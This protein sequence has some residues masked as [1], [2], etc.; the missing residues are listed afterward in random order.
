VSEGAL[1]QDEPPA[2]VAKEAERAL[3][4]LFRVA[5]ERY[6]LRAL[7]VHKVVEPGWINRLPRLPPSV[8]GITQHRGRIL[9]VV[10]L[11]AFF[12][13]PLRTL[14]PTSATRVLV[15]DKGQRNL[16]LYVDAVEQIATVR[17]PPARADGG[18]LSV[19]QHQGAAVNALFAPVL[20]E[21]LLALGEDAAG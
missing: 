16:G 19:F 7:D 1:E 12:G 8:V 13:A 18:A 11:A 6:A 17:V 4:L 21:R 10:D 14:E 20:L 9:T 15:L 5:G 2:K 3:C